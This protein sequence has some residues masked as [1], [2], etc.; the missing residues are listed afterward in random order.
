MRFSSHLGVVGRQYYC[1]GMV[2]CGELE[3][4]LRHLPADPVDVDWRLHCSSANSMGA[5]EGKNDS[6]N[7]LLEADA[8]RFG[9]NSIDST[10]VYWQ[11]ISGILKLL[12]DGII[13]LQSFDG[14]VFD[15]CFIHP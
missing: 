4:L 7:S 11:E 3:G 13:L 5:G 2:C 9:S 12:F 6:L 10:D 1:S 14:I 15:E 8:D